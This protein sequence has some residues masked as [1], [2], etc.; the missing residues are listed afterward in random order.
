MMKYEWVGL[1]EWFQG[2]MDTLDRVSKC[3]MD[4]RMSDFDGLGIDM[5]ENN[6]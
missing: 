5:D 3:L 1:F 4:D 6:R 2:P